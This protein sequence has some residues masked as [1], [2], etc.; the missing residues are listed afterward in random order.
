MTG[1]RMRPGLFV[2]KNFLQ[3]VIYYI[4]MIKTDMRSLQEEKTDKL[5]IVKR[6]ITGKSPVNI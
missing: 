6:I 4:Q 5:R 2:Q 3:T 1:L